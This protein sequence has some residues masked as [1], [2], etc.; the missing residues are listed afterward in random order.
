[1]ADIKQRIVLDG[2]KEY[3]QA[4][5]DAQ[6]ELKTLRSELKAETAELGKNATEQQKAEVRTKNLQKQIKEQEKV[7]Q[8][9]RK[10]LEEVRENYAD[11][12]DAIAKWEQK[13]N[14]AR[15]TL[16]NMKNSLGDV[17]EGLK[18]I[19][20][21]A[22]MGTV[23]TKSLADSFE[24]LAGI[25]SSISDAI[26]SVFTGMVDTVKGVVTELWGM[27]TDAAAK[28]NQWT[29]LA[30]YFGSTAEQVQL[31]N[32]AINASAGDF[33]K[34]T[35]L[36]SQL[37]FG[38]KNKKIT[39]WFGVSDANYTNNID[40]TMAVLDAM[41]KAY[42]EWGTGGKW[43]NAMS[44]IFG[45]KKSADVSWFVTNLESIRKNMAEFQDGGY[46]MDKDELETMNQVHLQLNEITE[47]WDALKAKFA[48]GFG[49]VTLDIMTNVEGALDALAKYFNAETPEEREKALQELEQNITEAFQKI[50]D[51]IRAGIEILGKV[52]EDLKNSDDPVTKTL[53]TVLDGIVT[54]LKWFTEDNANNVVKAFEIIA[55]FWITGKGLKMASSILGV[56]QNIKVIRGFNAIQGMSGAANMAAGIGGTA[57][58]S[59]SSI[60]T[61]AVTSCAGPLATAIAGITMT[62]GIAAL[63]VPV[64]SLLSEIIK[65]SWPEWLANPSKEEGE[66]LAPNADPETQKALTRAVTTGALIGSD[67]AKWALGERT[68]EEKAA[69]ATPTAKEALHWGMNKLLGGGNEQDQKDNPLLRAM[70]YNDAAQEYIYDDSWSIADIQADMARRKLEA[71]E[72]VIENIDLDA[73]SDSD[74]ENALQDWWDAWRE[75]A[76]DEE[77]A[78]EWFKETF[79]D[80]FSDTWDRIIAKVDELDMQG[81]DRP[82]DIPAD[83]W[84]GSTGENGVTSQDLQTLNSL[85]KDTKEAVRELIGSMYI[86]LDG[87]KVADLLTARVSQRIATTIEP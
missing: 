11:N 39:E 81:I 5:K 62:V 14:D 37:S 52:A 54:A 29:D 1:M 48:E 26:E 31:M 22:A 61:S 53:G 75:G 10:A 74:K 76:D 73:F 65:G 23:A 79:G 9:Y 87:E 41:S 8:T 84:K 12:E 42:K 6:R 25:G 58:T 40:Y 16:A 45:G 43:D 78:F 80:E 67:P 3:K 21:S 35:N 55:A 15:A 19:D 33:S 68:E 86:S 47:K 13:L 57:A 30:S 7:V 17:N 46:L 59:M 56:A 4:L 49:K 32:R 66:T 50:A 82:A 77:S 44:E 18:Q 34:F 2:E 83:W 36:V 72:E 70:E 63:A 85:P 60:I 71:L 69:G 28:A 38:G 27:I 51:A 64:I 20:Q 24:S